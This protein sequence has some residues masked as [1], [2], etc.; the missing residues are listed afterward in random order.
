[1][2]DKPEEAILA[3]S[4]N[5]HIPVTLDDIIRKNRELVELCLSTAEEI[6]A[7]GGEIRPGPPV[8]GIVDDW[9]I[10]SLRA[11]RSGRAQVV[12][13]GHSRTENAPWITSAIV[14]I[15]LPRNYVLTK[16][17]S[18]YELGSQGNGEPPRLQLIHVCATLHQW[19]SGVFLGV[20]HFFY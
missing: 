7:L 13:L 18:L 17:G 12:L 19:G 6:R 8:K 16:S 14:R 2:T 1:M 3:Q 9:R 4:I 15:D 11:K 5:D 10:I 20:P